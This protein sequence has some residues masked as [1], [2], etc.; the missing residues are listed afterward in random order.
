MEPTNNEIDMAKASLKYL[1]AVFIKIGNSGFEFL[2][3]TFPDDFDVGNI[4]QVLEELLQLRNVIDS[5]EKSTDMCIHCGKLTGPGSGLYVNRVQVLDS[6]DV[7]EETF[8]YPLGRYI[9][10]EC[11]EKANANNSN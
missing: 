1:Q 11:E 5:Y 3:D 7:R 6:F 8:D 4:H 9:C 10:R 2:R